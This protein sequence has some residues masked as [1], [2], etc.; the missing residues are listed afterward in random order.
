MALNDVIAHRRGF[1]MRTAIGALTAS[2]ILFAAQPASAQQG[3]Y[4][5]QYGN[6]NA[7]LPQYNT[8]PPISP[9]LNIVRGANTPG[10]NYYLGTRNDFYNQNFQYNT[11]SSLSSLQGMVGQPQDVIDI[12]AIPTLPQTGH[13]SAFQAYGSYY[14]YP[15]QRPFYPLNPGAARMLPR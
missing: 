3:N 13:L 14:N 1:A 2:L 9:Y 4:Y 11:L 6:M 10:I 5:P 7:R 12:G 8:P 15:Q